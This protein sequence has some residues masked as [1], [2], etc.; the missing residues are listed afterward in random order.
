[1]Q[2]HLIQYLANR[3]IPN[4]VCLTEAGEQILDDDGKPKTRDVEYGEL[5]LEAN[6]W[7]NTEQYLRLNYLVIAGMTAAPTGMRPGPQGKPANF[8]AQPKADTPEKAAP[9][10]RKTK[11]RRKKTSTRA[12]RRIEA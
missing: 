11:A 5:V 9:K 6:Y 7:P 3:R 12:S 10:P 4:V 8:V 1:M 2:D